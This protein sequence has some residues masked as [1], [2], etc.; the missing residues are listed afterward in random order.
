LEQLFPRVGYVEDAFEGRTQLAGFFSF[1]LRLG[2]AVVQMP[3]LPV[4]PSVTKFMGKNVPPS[5]HGQALA[6]ING[7]RVVV[8]DAIGI[9][10]SPVHLRIGNLTYGDPVAEGEHDSRGHTQHIR[11][12]ILIVR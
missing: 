3:M 8:P 4:E 7:L 11:L 1:L 5:G 10:V 2:F 9:G 6:K 12:V